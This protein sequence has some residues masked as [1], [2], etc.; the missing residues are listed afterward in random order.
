LRLT[1]GEA[2][3][4]LV[5]EIRHKTIEPSMAMLKGYGTTSF[6][7]AGGII[8]IDPGHGGSDPGCISRHYGVTEKEVT[9]DI[10][11]RLARILRSRGWNVVL[12]RTDDRDVSWAGS[13]AKEELGAR[14]KIAN[15][16][17]ADVFVS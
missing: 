10:S 7:A 15:D 5:L 6:P 11:L 9:L 17:G 1:P 13:S 14:V 4:T 3:N 2:A 12:T 16:M 8:C